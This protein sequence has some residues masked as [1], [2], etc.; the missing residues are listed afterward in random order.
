MSGKW[1]E[2]DWLGHQISKNERANYEFGYGK[3]L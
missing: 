3:D 2:K 1:L